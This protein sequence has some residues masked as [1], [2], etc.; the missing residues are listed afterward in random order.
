MVVKKDLST[1]LCFRA[2]SS[3]YIGVGIT[4]IPFIICLVAVLYRGFKGYDFWQ[5]IMI[6][7][8]LPALIFFWLRTIKLTLTDDS[9][10]YRTLFRG[11]SSLGCFEI[12]KVEVQIGYGKS[13]SGFSPPFRMH[14]VPKPF[15]KKRPIVVNMYV[16]SRED[17]AQIREFVKS[18]GF[19]IE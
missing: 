6:S 11:T 17:L 9:I 4:G 2:R 7:L 19:E 15:V 13:T 14:F 16:F 18:K 5:P 10:T 3:S 12:G 1:P 8:M